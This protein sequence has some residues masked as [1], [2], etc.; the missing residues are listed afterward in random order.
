MLIKKKLDKW[1]SEGEGRAE[2]TFDFR[3]SLENYRPE[4]IR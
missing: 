1:K 4:V 3:L 2:K